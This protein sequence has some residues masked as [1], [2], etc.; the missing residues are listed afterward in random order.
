MNKIKVKKHYDI[1][2]IDNYFIIDG[3]MI[4][5]KDYV[6]LDNELLDK[7]LRESTSSKWDSTLKQVI[8][9][10]RPCNW[11]GIVPAQPYADNIPMLLTDCYTKINNVS[12]RYVRCNTEDNIELQAIND[13]WLEK[14]LPKLDLY[15]SKSSNQFT[16]WK[17]NKLVAIIMPAMIKRTYLY[18]VVETLNLLAV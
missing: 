5:N 13:E 12:Y 10:A 8:E 9:C 11:S 4:I 3:A 18:Q 6:Q 1:L 2:S 14:Y 16:Q 17:D 15:Y 7:L